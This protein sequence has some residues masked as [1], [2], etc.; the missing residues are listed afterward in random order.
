MTDEKMRRLSDKVLA[1]FNQACDQ[2]DAE[3]AEML[4]RTLELIL[5]RQG[6]A[7]SDDKRG[8][9]GAVIDAYSRLLTIKNKA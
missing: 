5:T 4:L 9:L 8:D 6:G 1:A 3:I 7:D 2:E